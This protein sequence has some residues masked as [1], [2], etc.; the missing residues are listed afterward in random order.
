LDLQWERQRSSG[1]FPLDAEPWRPEA[2]TMTSAQ[3]FLLIWL[4]K[5]DASALGECE[6]P[7]LD[8]L[9]AEGFATISPP[10]DPRRNGYRRVSLT[11]AGHAKARELN[12]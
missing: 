12:K 2:K 8:F 10:T 1:R 6:G 3:E 9:A 4:S 11:D 7:A 5:E